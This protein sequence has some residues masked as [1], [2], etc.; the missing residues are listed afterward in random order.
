MQANQPK[1]NLPKARELPLGLRGHAWP[2]L[3]IPAVPTQGRGGPGPRRLHS[4]PRHSGRARTSRWFSLKSRSDNRKAEAQGVC[5]KTKELCPYRLQGEQEL[6]RGREPGGLAAGEDTAW[7]A[8]GAGG[9]GE[10]AGV[11]RAGPLAL[12]E[13]G[14]RSC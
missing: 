2:T 7:S 12:Q 4:E 13:A 11:G 9:A 1:A 6:W 5:G 10:R 8:G 14:G 3:G